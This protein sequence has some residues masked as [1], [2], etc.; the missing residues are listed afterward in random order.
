MSHG[1]SDMVPLSAPEIRR[2]M[3]RLAQQF[4]EPDDL[5]WHWS[6]W[7]RRHQARAQ[8]YHYKK[9]AVIL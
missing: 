7:R 1:V 8:F 5:V 4:T 6:F 9:R 2:L 3:N